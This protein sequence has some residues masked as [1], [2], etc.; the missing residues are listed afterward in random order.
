M[1][2]TQ[3]KQYADN[4]GELMELNATMGL[5]LANQPCH[6]GSSFLIRT[7]DTNQPSLNCDISSHHRRI[8]NHDDICFSQADFVW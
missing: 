5:S 8:V 7:T 3:D 4:A 1:V 6:D 2:L